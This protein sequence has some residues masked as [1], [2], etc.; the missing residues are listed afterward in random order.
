MKSPNEIIVCSSFAASVAGFNPLILKDKPSFEIFYSGLEIY[1]KIP[2]CKSASLFLLN[3]AD[4]NFLYRSS[5]GNVNETEI[6]NIFNEL[7]QSGSISQ[8]L[9]SGECLEKELINHSNKI[10]NYLIIPLNV[11]SGIIGL[12]ILNTESSIS[13]QNLIMNLCKIFSNYFAQL[14][15]STDLKKEIE[16]LKEITE[17]KI[18]FRT[19]DIAKSTRELKAILD[20]VQV[21]IIIVDKTSNQIVD[22]NLVATET[23]G[24]SKEKLIGINEDAHFIFTERKAFSSGEK[25]NGEVLLKKNNGALI[26]IILTISNISL[27][28][29][30]FRIES[31]IDITERKKMEDELQKAHYE[32]ELKVEKRTQE[33]SRTNLELQNQI[34]ERIKLEEE[35][36]KLYWAVQ[37]SPISVAIT[38]LD[39][40]IEYVNPQF[41]EMNGYSFEEVKGKDSFFL[42]NE[43]NSPKELK[44]LRTNV[45]RGNKWHGELKNKRNDGDE[46][47]VSS[48][49]SPMENINGQITNYLEIEEDITKKVIARQ[50]LLR[51][52]EKAEEQDRLK[53]RLLAN[54]SHEFR[55]PLSGILGFAQILINEIKDRSLAEMAKDIYNSGKRLMDTLNGVLNLSQLET[56]DLSLS[57]EVKNLP[58]LLDQLKGQ[59]ISAA[60]AKSIDYKVEIIRKQ[61]YVSIDAKLFSQAIDYLIQNAIK[62]TGKGSVTIIVDAVQ[63]G[64][65]KFAVIKIHDTGVG[66]HESNQKIIFEAFRQVSEGYNRDYE[67]IGLGLTLAQ[68]I[69]NLMKGYISVESEP[70]K[71]STFTIYL[72]LVEKYNPKINL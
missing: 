51:A 49:L 12:S 63:D 16:Y 22:A 64:E 70:S 71:G 31:F 56:M 66:I 24:V 57:T 25:V 40:N 9:S 46:F 32:L 6:T 39:G 54:L 26:P 14:I 8:V 48:F 34:R 4:F 42:K 23:I 61:L 10:D 29:D 43:T 15:N 3:E 21:G 7:I 27:D 5:A 44:I 18:A 17:Q 52:K 72:P 41:T 33:L 50:G 37:Q 11:Q 36:I 67:G 68:K 65:N 47:W 60:K 28:G 62:F 13:S 59:Y 19:N 20:S 30:E 69:V 55:T 45:S 2:G 53:S 1:K 35:R 58:E 38:D